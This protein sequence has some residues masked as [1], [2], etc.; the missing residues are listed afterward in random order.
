MSPTS[1]ARFTRIGPLQDGAVLAMDPDIPLARQRLSLHGPPGAWSVDGRPYGRGE[2][3]EWPLAP[4]RHVVELRDGTRLIDRV[5][6]E[7]RRLK[8]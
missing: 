7:V 3:I 6:F 8:P 5:R 4:G 1:C 2:S